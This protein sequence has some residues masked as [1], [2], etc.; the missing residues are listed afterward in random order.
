ML[1]ITISV[2]LG[3]H[4]NSTERRTNMSKVQIRVSGTK[5]QSLVLLS[6]GLVAFHYPSPHLKYLK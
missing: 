1:N 3:D 4:E 5:T 2:A 6:W